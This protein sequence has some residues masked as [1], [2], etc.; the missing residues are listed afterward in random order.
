MREL[1][2]RSI[3][4]PQ[5]LDRPLY[6]ALCGAVTPSELFLEIRRTLRLTPMFRILREL[7]R[8]GVNLS[9]LNALEMF[10]GSGRL[11]TV[12]Y[13]PYVKSLEAWEIDPRLAP[14][15]IENL[16]AATVRTVDSFVELRLTKSRY[17]LIFIDPPYEMFDEH[18]EHFDLFPGVFGLLNP[19]AILVLANVR[20]KIVMH[21]RYSDKH[22]ER[23][24]AFYGVEDP[25]SIS[26]EQMLKAYKALSFK[27]GFE[28][29]WSL[30]ID[31]I[32]M[33]PLQKHSVD[34]TCFLILALQKQ[35][36]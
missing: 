17:D 26:L 33:Y 31:R 36:D 5:W 27:N 14:I 34:R 15:L 29:K 22:L 8:R 2:A 21:E 10:S 3:H 35:N 19:C 1:L 11:Y 18:C 16:P 13:A 28:I 23:R 20:L 9:S 25:K 24:R 4:R 30:L 32:V 6:P 12:D 7:K